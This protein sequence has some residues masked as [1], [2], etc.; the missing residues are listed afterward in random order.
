MKSFK[1]TSLDG[2]RKRRLRFIREIRRGERDV[3]E[4]LFVRVLNL[5]LKC[6]TIFEDIFKGWNR[7]LSEFK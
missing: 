4:K 1:M 7:K 5:I 3:I 6:F 2:A